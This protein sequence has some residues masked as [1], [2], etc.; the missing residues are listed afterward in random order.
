MAVTTAFVNFSRTLGGVFGLAIA[1]T[2]FNN[3]L[4]SGLST[5]N[6][7]PDVIQQ[8]AN[9]VQYIDSLTGTERDEIVQQYV[10]A[11]Q[12]C[13]RIMIPF[14][15]CAFLCTLGIKHSPLRKSLGDAKP[16]ENK[17]HSPNAET[18]KSPDTQTNNT[19]TKD[20]EKGDVDIRQVD[21]SQ[22]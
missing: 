10:N 13:F 3:K 12:L 17:E 16:T 7:T 2:L 21:S 9:D 20:L 4:L 22:A 19:S 8:A 14:G 11:L 18:A 6:L 1:G 15:G 5:L